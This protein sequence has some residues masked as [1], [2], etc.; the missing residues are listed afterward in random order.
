[1]ILLVAGGRDIRLSKA[2]N[3]FLD[4]LNKLHSFDLL[5]NGGA[6]GIDSEA[7]A[8]A[9]LQS[10]PVELYKA[11]W[12]HGRRAGPERNRRMAE[13]CLKEPSLICLLKG[14]RGTASMFAEATKIGLEIIDVRDRL[15]YVENI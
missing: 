10:I 2:G 12:A 5:I 9:K 15:D 7:R 6:A 13:R 14:G 4:D 11:E 3:A 1:M 8:W